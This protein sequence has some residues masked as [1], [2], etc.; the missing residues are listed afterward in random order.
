MQ[1]TS[2]QA[3]SY[4]KRKVE[5]LSES[6]KSVQQIVKERQLFLGNVEQMLSR[7]VAAARAAEAA[8]TSA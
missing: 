6:L 4:C 7:K 3:Q 1:M 5:K 2:D 8:S